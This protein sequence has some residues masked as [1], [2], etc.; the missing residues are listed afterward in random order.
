DGAVVGL[1]GYRLQENLIHGRFVYIDDLVVAQ[2]E[3]RGRIG[4]E[5]LEAVAAEARAL[6]CQRLTLDTAIDNLLG[7]RF[8]FRNGMLATGLHFR[9]SLT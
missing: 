4:A 9:L 5:L 6:G 8:Y 3:R 7:Q 2:S 1:A